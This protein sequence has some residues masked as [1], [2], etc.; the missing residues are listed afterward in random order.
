MGFV[1]IGVVGGE[2]CIVSF[3]M[4]LFGERDELI[5]EDL[6][7]RNNGRYSEIRNISDETNFN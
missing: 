2:R 7:P 3:A 6:Y 5:D 1:A 4:D